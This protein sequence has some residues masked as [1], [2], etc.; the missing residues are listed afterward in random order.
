MGASWGEL[1]A[2]AANAGSHSYQQTIRRLIRR[3]YL[4]GAN[5]DY[6]VS[7]VAKMAHEALAA[8]ETMVALFESSSESWVAYSSQGERL[9][10]DDILKRGSLSILE[11]TRKDAEP[12]L[13][14]ADLPEELRTASVMSHQVRSVLAV[15][16]FWWDVRHS[17]PKKTFGGC[18][19]TYRSS[20]DLAFTGDDVELVLDISAVAERHL[21]L[22]RYVRGVEAELNRSKQEL[23][24]LRQVVAEEY[25]LGKYVTLDRWFG[26][27]VIGTLRRLSHADRVTILLQGPTGSGKSHLAQAYHYECPRRQGPFVTLDC[28]QVTSSETLAAELFG[29]ASR[30]GFAN[31]P[32]EGSQG[33]AQRAD[34]GTLLID[35][36]SLLPADLQPRLLGLIQTGTF[37]ALGTSERRQVDIQIIAATNEDLRQLVAQGRFREDLFWRLSEVS[38]HLV[39]LTSRAADIPVLAEQFLRGARERFKIAGMEGISREALNLLMNHDWSRA[40][41]IRGLENTVRRSVLLAPPGTRQLEVE[42]L[43]FEQLGAP[44]GRPAGGA[45]EPA[46]PG[47]AAAPAGLP[48]VAPLKRVRGKQ[49]Q[50][51]LQ[52]IIAAVQ[53]HGYASDAAEALGMSYTMLISRLRSAGLS[54]RDVLAPRT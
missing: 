23:A 16:L 14:T 9:T 21:N 2:G 34:G 25:R 39:P 22:L 3:D 28:S 37:T 41:N 5:W 35:E 27:Q 1:I 33:A 52:S 12:V 30:S 54:V 6:A 48:A 8:R 13:I 32:K 4:T 53:E 17:P 43:R 49:K 7:D 44:A 38:I 18:L 36:V 15:P 20:A 47:G 51:E 40:G 11:R 29:Y 45:A 46:R 26:E 24:E 10:G 50:D 19:C 42:H 31:A